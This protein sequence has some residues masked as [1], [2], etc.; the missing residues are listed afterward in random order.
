MTVT[1]VYTVPQN[2]LPEATQQSQV[3]NC[4]SLSGTGI[5]KQ[6][7]DFLGLSVNT[8]VTVFVPP[9]SP[10]VLGKFVRTI[11]LQALSLFLTQFA[12]TEVRKAAVA[13][14]FLGR[15]QHNAITPA[16]AE[17]PVLT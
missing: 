10:A 16:T 12:T 15:I 3:A 17:P 4:L 14:L 13:G 11:T 1:L 7:L 8:D 5:D 6:A 9:V 2:L